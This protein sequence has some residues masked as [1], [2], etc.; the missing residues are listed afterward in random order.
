[1]MQDIPKLFQKEMG[2]DVNIGF[3]MFDRWFTFSP[4][5][6]SSF[7]GNFIFSGKKASA[8]YVF[9]FRILLNLELK[10]LGKEVPHLVQCH[11]QNQTN[12][13]RIKGS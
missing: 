3:T 11:Q 7:T 10:L 13:F 8:N 12:T 5:K 4:A 2:T 1:M 9:V 6:V